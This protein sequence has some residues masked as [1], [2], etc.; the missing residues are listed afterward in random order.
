MDELMTGR[1]LGARQSRVG[2]QPSNSAGTDWLGALKAY[3]GVTIVANLIWETLHL[4][5][6]TIWTTGTLQQQAFAVIHCNGGDVLIALTTLTIGLICVG[7][8]DWP[9]AGHLPVLLLTLASGIGYT[10]FSE[11]LNVV[12]RASWAYAPTMPVVPIINTGLS[13]FMQWTL[14]PILALSVA[15]KVALSH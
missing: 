14:V 8:R 10:I 1:D 12:V 7:T 3:I 9:L 13:P 4:P 15:R 11:W 2:E 6:Y 5:L